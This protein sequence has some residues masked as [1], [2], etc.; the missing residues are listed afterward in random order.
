MAPSHTWTIGSIELHLA[1][2]DLFALD[3]AAIVNSEQTNFHLAHG[4]STISGQI[5]RRLGNGIQDEL[6]AQTQGQVLPPGTVLKTTGGARYEFVYHAGFHRPGEWLGGPDRD[7]Q[8]ADALRTVMYCVR[9]ILNDPEAPES[10]AFPLLATGLFGLDPALVAYELAREAALVG[11][12]GGERRSVWLAVRNNTYHAIVDAMVQG[13]I[14][15][16]QGSTPIGD[17][18][19]GI[20]YLDR[21]NRSQ[22]RSGDARFLA[23]MV[24]RYTE[25][26]LGYVLSRLAVASGPCGALGV[27]LPPGRSMSFGIARSESQN[28]ALKLEAAPHLDPWAQHLVVLVLEDMR[29]HHRLLRINDDRNLL[30]HGKQARPLAAIEADLRGFLHLK[31]WTGLR[32][33][34]GDPQVDGLEP[35]VRRVELG[36]AHNA[37]LDYGVLDRWTTKYY[38]YLVPETGLTLRAKA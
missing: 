29:S 26:L 4:P 30:A 19:L 12:A 1:V 34:L 18:E 33:E 37:L 9:E 16:A 36:K 38:D 28:L 11:M 27:L 31:I 22:V 32:D 24:A 2:A 5:R 13:L 21:F 17:I 23:W 35:W 6:F 25:L 14:D 7:Q 3:V 8:E 20:G 15:S 10:I